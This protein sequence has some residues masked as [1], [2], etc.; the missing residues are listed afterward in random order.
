MTSIDEFQG[1]YRF[2]SNFWPAQI[3]LNGVVYRSVE[4]A[5]MAA[6]SVD[7]EWHRVCAETESP[8]AVKRASRGIVLR[9][10]WDA[11]RVSVMLDCL[12]QK[13]AVDP[14]RSNLLATG[15]AYLQEGNRWGDTFWGVDLRKSPP[16]GANTLGTLLMQ[17][18]AELRA[19]TC[20]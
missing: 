12:R 19:S 14:L 4:H 18:R 2:L 16:V 5:Y 3:A 8:A 13:F 15:D 9:P 10:D 20:A 7:P 1:P 6:K 17:V 11:A